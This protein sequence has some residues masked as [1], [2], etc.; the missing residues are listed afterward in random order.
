MST[1]ETTYTLKNYDQLHWV[2]WT[3]LHWCTSNKKN[4]HSKQNDFVLLNSG[5]SNHSANSVNGGASV[6]AMLQFRI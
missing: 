6:Y 2:W 4:K 3:L 5:I 1:Q